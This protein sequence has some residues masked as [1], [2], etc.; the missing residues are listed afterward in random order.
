MKILTEREMKALINDETVLTV[1]R[2][3]PPMD[4]VD[5]SQRVHL[6]GPTGTVAVMYLQQMTVRHEPQEMSAH[7][8]GVML[9]LNTHRLASGLFRLQ[10][11]HAVHFED[12]VLHLHPSKTKPKT[13]DLIRKVNREEFVKAVS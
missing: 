6:W 2:T 13:E 7:T 1:L 5:I 11:F 9:G 8:A 10:R 3:E 4:E 12:G